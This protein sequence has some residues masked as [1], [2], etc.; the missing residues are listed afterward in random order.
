MPCF[1]W[2]GAT[3]GSSWALPPPEDGLSTVVQALM[4]SKSAAAAN[5]AN[6][7]LL[8]IK[9]N[10]VS[11]KMDMPFVNSQSAVSRVQRYK[12]YR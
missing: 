10:Y 8:M 3:T 11:N 2:A 4:P 12:E 6:N 1:S 5:N 7:S 9:I